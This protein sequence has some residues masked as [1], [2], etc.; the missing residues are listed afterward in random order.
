[1]QIEYRPFGF[2][3]KNRQEIRDRRMG[4]IVIF[5][6]TVSGLF[7]A[8]TFIWSAG[9][10]LTFAVPPR[11]RSCFPDCSGIPDP[12][13]FD[14]HPDVG[15]TRERCLKR[16]CCFQEPSEDF[17][18]LN[19]PYCYFPEGYGGYE[20]SDIHQEANEVRASL[21][22]KIPSGFP[23]DVQELNLLVSTLR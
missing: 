10:F 19:V 8:A 3:G 15:V 23:S 13:K 20:I 22:R 11:S 18:P 6:L 1:M 4:R 14:C 5:L 9:D 2:D 16:G 21:K 7:F 17:P 12:K